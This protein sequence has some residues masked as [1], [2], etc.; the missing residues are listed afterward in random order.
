MIKIIN[1]TKI[2]KSRNKRR[3][4]ALNNL[5]F[6]LPDKGFVFIIG[7][8]GSGKSTLLNLL[9][10]LDDATR[11]K[12]IADGNNIV[13]F[14]QR[15]FNMY[16]SSYAGFIF[17]D[18]HLL[19]EL[20]VE[21]NVSL[22]LD[23][24]T[25]ITKPMVIEKLR[26]VGL[27]EYANSFPSE[28]S[29]GQQQR[30][31]IARV[32]AKQPHVILCDEPTGNLD[33]KTSTSILELLKEISKNQLVIIVSHNYQDALN[34][35]D[36][37]IELSEGRIIRDV[38]KQ[39]KYSNEFRFVDGK[40]V[41]PYRKALNSKEVKILMNAIENNEV[42]RIV[43]NGDGY[44]NTKSI[45]EDNESTFKMK[46]RKITKNNLTKLFR[47]FFRKNKSS[48]VV[49]VVVASLIMTFLSIIQSFLAF[50][51]GESIRDNL[52][53]K[54]ETAF[55]IQ[56]TKSSVSTGIYEIYDDEYMD[57]VSNG[58]QGNAYKLYNYNVR[59]N[60][61]FSSSLLVQTTPTLKTNIGSFFIRETY[62]TLACDKE[63]LLNKYG[64]NDNL[65]YKAKSETFGENCDDGGVIIT[66]YVAD[67]MI[68]YNPGV[69]TSYNDLIGNIYSNN[70]INSTY[71]KI[72]AII[73]TNYENKY[74]ELRNAALEAINNKNVDFNLEKMVS[75]EEYTAFVDDVTQYL[76]IC[77]SFNPNFYESISS[78]DHK[79]FVSLKNFHFVNDGKIKKCSTGYY[80][81]DY[82]NLNSKYA[83]ENEDE[84]KISVTIYN[85]LFGTSYVTD[86]NSQLYY[87][88]VEPHKITIQR[89]KDNDKTKELL[90]SKELTVTALISSPS[91]FVMSD[92]VMQEL[93]RFDIIPYALYFDDLHSLDSVV[94]K[95]GEDTYL[96]IS[97]DTTNVRT[98]NRAVEVFEDLF[99]LFEYIL[100][101]LALVYIV[102]Y[103]IRSI[104]K[105]RYQ[106]G[107]I[108]SLGGSALN[109][110][111]IFS[112]KTIIVGFFIC[113]VSY[114]GMVYLNGV[115]NN[116]LIES[117]ESFIGRKIYNI[118]IIKVRY[119]IIVID[120]ILVMLITA[121]SS[122]VPI[123]VLRK[124]KPAYILKA[125]E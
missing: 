68:V 105:H 57:L 31:A 87:G 115:A 74:C 59:T 77:Y 19:E 9:G 46:Y 79:G 6:T 62:G 30:V 26:L 51:G 96:P 65:Y 52:I 27:E 110:S 82:Y 103:G 69:Y 14:S 12:I 107:I 58:Y 15:K 113:I 118:D 56:K 100:F 120:L 122:L 29:G 45:K 124:I 114:F 121:I 13:N 49:T 80:T 3:C 95:V 48:S 50:N 35:G 8:S 47:A 73:D 10:G 55:V 34:Y 83:V 112:I 20:T 111:S 78:N 32:L 64:V 67:S 125:K 25:N 37:I 88:N 116:I 11:G 1:L 76:G 108:K 93:K 17:Q 101:V 16:R 24:N 39:K 97:L 85:A 33:E 4:I 71:A 41:L 54:N 75:V 70:N 106:I 81:Y 7:K 60:A 92:K 66:D 23:K 2:F 5:S 40:V 117:F 104:T 90:Y 44:K 21:E 61:S 18:Y 43:Q 109:I 42:K 98:I 99:L 63:Y 91:A 84:L 123:L 89:Y 86:K 28:L 22:F 119:N 38:E 102:N 53:A 72:S 36:R 94:S